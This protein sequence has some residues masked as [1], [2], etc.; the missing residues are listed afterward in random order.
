[1]KT[2]IMQPYIFPYVGYYQLINAVD[3]F[4]V[5]D[6]VNFIKR[7]W[8]NRNNILLNN[9]AHLFSIPLERPSQN[10]LICETK[11]NFSIQEKEHFIKTFE[12][13]YKKA[14]FFNDFFPIFTEIILYDSKDLTDFLCNS[15]N[16]T[17]KYLEIEKKIIR[18]S[19][20]PKNNTLKAEHRIIEICKKL[21]TVEYIN[22]SGGKSLYSQENFAKENIELRF[23][24]TRFDNIHY[25][26]FKNSFMPNL[27]FFDVIM[28][29]QKD[30]IK[31][32]LDQYSLVKGV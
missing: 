9:K 25:K 5:L 11:L 7:G 23:I 2:A 6:D 30:E 15:F 24:D 32:I 17:F 26:Q 22:L 13:A 19:E 10:K 18:S 1:M 29:N 12:L 20:I 27:S 14:P 31:R 4:V 28:F 16:E 21:N 8:I 3:I